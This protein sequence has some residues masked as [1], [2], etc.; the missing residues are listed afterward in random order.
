MKACGFLGAMKSHCNANTTSSAWGSARCRYPALQVYR[1]KGPAILIMRPGQLR[2]FSGLNMTTSRIF[3]SR[4]ME[5][6]SLLP[7]SSALHSRLM[8]FFRFTPLSSS[9][10]FPPPIYDRD[11]GFTFV[12]VSGILFCFAIIL[13]LVSAGGGLNTS[14]YKGVSYD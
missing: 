11:R 6:S 4:H 14:L 12:V 9:D 1:T 5:D 13:I 2:R 8:I 10:A 7:R 3:F